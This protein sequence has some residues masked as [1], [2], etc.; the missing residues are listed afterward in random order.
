VGALT[1][2]LELGRVDPEQRVTHGADQGEQRRPKKTNAPFSYPQ[3]TIRERGRGVSGSSKQSIKQ[4]EG[5]EGGSRGRFGDWEE[6]ESEVEGMRGR[7]PEGGGNS[8]RR[9]LTKIDD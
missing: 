9:K 2:Q 7:T 1:W 4:A 3:E 5:Y 8:G 6:D